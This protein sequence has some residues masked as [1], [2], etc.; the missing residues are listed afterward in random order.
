L[1][2]IGHPAATAP[3][4]CWRLRHLRLLDALVVA[5]GG[6]DGCASFMVRCIKSFPV[7]DVSFLVGNLLVNPDSVGH[8]YPFSRKVAVDVGNDSALM[9][10][11]G[12][13]VNVR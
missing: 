12:I 8:G 2:S 7:I 9:G 1:N 4:N 3:Q 10:V 5:E 6:E 11:A 13:Q